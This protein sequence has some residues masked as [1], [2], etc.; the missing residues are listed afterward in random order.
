LSVAKPAT[1]ARIKPEDN[2]QDTD[3]QPD[4]AADADKIHVSQWNPPI[5]L[6]HRTT[7]K[8]AEGCES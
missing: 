1:A 4:A 8:A 2:Q 5:S 3:K 6:L 7:A